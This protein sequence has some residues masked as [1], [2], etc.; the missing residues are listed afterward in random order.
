[1]EKKRFRILALAGSLRQGSYNRGLLRAGEE[2]APEWVEVQFFD[3][4]TLP[5]FNE[6]LEV[7]GDPEAVRRFK[8]AIRHANAVLMATPEYNGAVPGVLA[9]AMDW[10]SRPLSRSILG[11]KPVGV[12]LRKLTPGATCIICAN[13]PFVEEELQ[14]PWAGEMKDV[15]LSMKAEAARAKALDQQLDRLSLGKWAVL[16]FLL[17]FAVPFDNNQAE[18]YL[19]MIKCNKRSL[20][21]S[22]PKRERRCFVVFARISRPYANKGLRCWL[23]SIKLLLVIPF[24]LPLERDCSAKSF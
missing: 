19:R 8:E 22:A 5:S 13:L 6:D 11:N 24:F 17:D 4:G 18:R 9:N 16:R 21:A 3:I 15:L 7:A 10:A 1:M 2:L 14:Q 12:S 20:G 23:H